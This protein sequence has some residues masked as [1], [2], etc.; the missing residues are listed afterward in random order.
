[1][2]PIQ[3]RINRL[4]IAVA[5][6]AANLA[7]LRV[8]FQ[9]RRI[10]VLFGGALLWVLLEIGVL[11]AIRDRRGSRSFWLG[12]VGFGTIATLSYLAAVY[13]PQSVVGMMWRGYLFRAEVMIA[14]AFESSYKRYGIGALHEEIF[15]VADILVWVLPIVPTAIAGA[16]LTRRARKGLDRWLEPAT[17]ALTA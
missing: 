15:A 1:M 10:D 14:R 2:K 5:L 16:T 12:F 11:R 9:S 8:L 7:A 13:F 6:V 4:M 17:K 3:F